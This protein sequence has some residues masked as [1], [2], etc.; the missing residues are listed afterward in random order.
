MKAEGRAGEDTEMMPL[1]CLVLAFTCAL[2]VRVCVCVGGGVELMI[3]VSATWALQHV[4]ADLTLKVLVRDPRH[5]V[6]YNIFQ[7]RV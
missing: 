3:H 4:L 5:V 7:I 2:G 6:T 1:P